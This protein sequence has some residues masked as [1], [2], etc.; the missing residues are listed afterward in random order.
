[1]LLQHPEKHLHKM[2]LTLLDMLVLLICYFY[3][4]FFIGIE[5]K[6][7]GGKVSNF[8]C[9]SSKQIILSETVWTGSTSSFSSQGNGNEIVPKTVTQLKEI[10]R[11]GFGDI[12]K[13]GSV[14]LRTRASSRET[15][16]K[17]SEE[18]ISINFT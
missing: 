14:T 17:K 15:E 5:C 9:L 8:S 7:Y 16:E 10:L 6:H 12:C 11:I 2:H 3:L 1:M 18:V 13:E 4:T